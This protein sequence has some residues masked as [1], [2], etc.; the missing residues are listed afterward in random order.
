[1]CG[2]SCLHSDAGVLLGDGYHFPKGAL[3]TLGKRDRYI[4]AHTHTHT[5][6]HTYTYTY[7]Y[8]NALGALNSR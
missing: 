3:G 8:T 5:H 4:C 2:N 1:M 6:T 7:T